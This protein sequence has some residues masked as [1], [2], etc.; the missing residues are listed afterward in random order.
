M[1]F[2]KAIMN[3]C[4]TKRKVVVLEDN[5]VDATFTTCNKF[6]QRMQYNPWIILVLE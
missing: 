2:S 5:V 1:A 3:Q 6:K 4:I